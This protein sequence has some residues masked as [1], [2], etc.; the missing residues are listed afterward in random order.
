MK[1]NWINNSIA[2]IVLF[3]SI[4]AFA[5][6]EEVLLTI[7]GDEITVEEFEAIYNKNNNQNQNIEQKTVEEYVDLYINFKLKVKEA[8]ALGMD[9]VEAFKTELDGYLKQLKEPY[10]I[11]Q[12]YNQSLMKEAYD[13]MQ[14]DVKASHILIKVEKDALPKDTL[15]AYN[16]AD[17]IRNLLVNGASFQELAPKVPLL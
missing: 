3:I 10:L 6:K 9:T 12:D 5:Q 2:F 4:N 11:D 15:V 16:K 13:R 1:N 7:E 17:S 8:E 14:Y